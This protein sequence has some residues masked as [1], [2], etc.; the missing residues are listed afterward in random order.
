M[1]ATFETLD[2][3]GANFINSCLE[4]FAKTF[5]AEAQTQLEDDVNIV[6]SILSNYVPNCLVR[7]EV[8]CPI[9]DLKSKD[10]KNPSLFAEKFKQAVSI[11]EV[12]PYR[13]VTHNQRYN[14]RH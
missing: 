6:M 3:M 10:I 7:A 12:E 2:A 1:H 8:S 11:A 4:Q 14:E 9:S 13:A 5:K